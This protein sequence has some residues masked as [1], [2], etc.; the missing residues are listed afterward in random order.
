MTV[1]IRSEHDK[2]S[3]YRQLSHMSVPGR[4][5]PYSHSRF[6]LTLPLH[7]HVP[8]PYSHSLRT[9]IPTPYSHS[10]FTHILASYSHSHF[11]LTFPLHIHITTPYSHSHAV[12]T[13]PL[14][15]HIPTLHSHT[16]SIVTFFPQVQIVFIIV[17]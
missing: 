10:H 14:H 9:H 2:V 3:C 16:H 13:F 1:Y 11:V 4:S 12:L 17:T 6:V 15:T 7:T 8:T 5:T